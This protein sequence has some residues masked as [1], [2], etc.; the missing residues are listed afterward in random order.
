MER[1]LLPPLR[2]GAQEVTTPRLDQYLASEPSAR[3]ALS[4]L[5]RPLCSGVSGS[6]RGGAQSSEHKVRLESED[7]DF[8]LLVLAHPHSCPERLKPTPVTGALRELSQSPVTGSNPA[9]V[10]RRGYNRFPSGLPNANAATMSGA[11]VLRC[12]LA[13]RAKSARELRGPRAATGQGAPRNVDPPSR[14][15]AA[16][17]TVCLLCC[18]T[19]LR[20]RMDT[21]PRLGGSRAAVDGLAGH[22]EAM[23]RPGRALERAPCQRAR[24]RR[25]APWSRPSR[26][27]PGAWPAPPC[28]AGGR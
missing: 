11:P 10:R 23:R 24:A 27:R 22:R 8:D 5:T 2:L 9:R 17:P 19:R 12:L 13:W 4:S 18:A 3:S 16:P 20:T 6:P 1:D 14:A 26:P 28:S 21:Q 15:R 7:A 25:R